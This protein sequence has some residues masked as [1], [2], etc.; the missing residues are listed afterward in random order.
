[1]HTY[2]YRWRFVLI[3]RLSNG[4][5]PSSMS[6]HTLYRVAKRHTIPDLYRSL[7]AKKSCSYWLFC[8]KRPA[9]YDI[10]CLFATLYEYTS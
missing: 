5:L 4:V 6:A 3:E 2:I 8:G 7:C 9:S 1:M 10:L